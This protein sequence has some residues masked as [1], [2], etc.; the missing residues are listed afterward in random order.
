MAKHREP[1][2]AAGQAAGVACHLAEF[3]QQCCGD[4][5]ALGDIAAHRL[6]IA[7]MAEEVESDGEIAVA[8]ERQGKWLH[9]LLR[10]GEAMGDHHHRGFARRRRPEQRDRRGTASGAGDAQSLRGAAELG[11]REGDGADRQHGRERGRGDARV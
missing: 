9:Q 10:A 7:T 1:S 4:A 8:R 2:V 6:R 11:D 5:G 3:L